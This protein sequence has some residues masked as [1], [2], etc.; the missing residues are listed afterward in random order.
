MLDCRVQSARRRE[1]LSDFACKPVGVVE[2]TEFA[3]A[4]DPRIHTRCIACPPDAGA[5]EWFCAWEFTLAPD[6]D[7]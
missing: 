5:R 1:G 7:R 3:R 4:I 2:Y 6:G